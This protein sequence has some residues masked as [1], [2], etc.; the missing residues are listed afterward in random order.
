MLQDEED[1][2]EEPDAVIKIPSTKVKRLIG[3]GGAKIKEVQN[4]CKAR[5]QIMKTEEELQVRGEGGM[6]TLAASF[7]VTQSLYFPKLSFM[8]I[9]YRVISPATDYTYVYAPS[10]LAFFTFQYSQVGLKGQLQAK[11]REKIMAQ[12]QSKVTQV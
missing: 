5:L 8:S 6:C 9:P 1:D 2:V 3:A 10:F 11:E 4:K 7:P 12:L